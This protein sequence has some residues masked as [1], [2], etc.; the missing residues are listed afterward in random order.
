[1][2]PMRRATGASTRQPRE[3][4]YRGRAYAELPTPSPVPTMGSESGVSHLQLVQPRA[5]SGWG[6]PAFQVGRRGDSAGDKH[7]LVQLQEPWGRCHRSQDKEGAR[8]GEG[9]GTWERCRF[10][11]IP[12]SP[13]WPRSCLGRCLRRC[14][15]P[16][17]DPSGALVPT[18]ETCHLHPKQTHGVEDP[19]T[20]AELVHAVP[21]E[22]GQPTRFWGKTHDLCPHTP[23]SYPNPPASPCYSHVGRQL[24]PHPSRRG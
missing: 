1:M 14:P 3:G 12:A 24:N 8:W 13:R 16:S 11:Y 4:L 15:S 19:A 21:A 17:E 9:A 23:P 10:P 7:T 2:A 20:A 22:R 18:S 6:E 5:L